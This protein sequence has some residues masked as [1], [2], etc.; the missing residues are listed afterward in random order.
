MD[1]LQW[2]GNC[3]DDRQKGRQE[4]F[5]R[6]TNRN[7]NKNTTVTRMKRILVALFLM[8]GFAGFS[9]FGNQQTQQDLV[10]WSYTTEKISETDYNLI[11]KASIEPQWHVYSQFTKPGGPMPLE[12]SFENSGTDFELVG[13]AEEGDTY[14]EYNDIFEV[15]ETF[16]KD[17]LLVT[18]R[19][20]L[21]KG[22]IS[23]VQGSL[24][25]Q[26]CKDVCIQGNQDFAF[27]LTGVKAETKKKIVSERDAELSAK[28]VLPLKNTHYI[29]NGEAEKSFWQV[30]VL[31]FLGG[32][33]ALFTPCVFPMIPLTVSFFTKQSSNKTKGKANA[34][35]YGFFIVAIYL[36]LSLPFHLI[37]GVNKEVLNNIST[38]AYLNTGF[39]V[40]F[41]VFAISFFGYFEITLPQSWSNKMDNASNVGGLL[42]IFFMAV[43][44]A[45]VSFSCTGPIL[46][47]LLAGS[48]SSDGGAMQ[49][50]VGMGGFGLALALPFAIFALFPNLLTS[51]PK[52]GGWMTTTKVFL[53]YL[54]LAFAFKFFSNAD[55]VMHWGILKWEIFVGVWILI[56][57]LLTLYMFGV[58]RFPH[59]G[60]GKLSK[61]RLAIGVISG[62]FSVYLIL[63]LVG[64]NKLELLSGFPPQRSYSLF[65]H[66]EKSEL[67]VFQDFD[68]G[69]AFAKENDKLV[70]LDFTGWAC[71]NCRKV[72]EQIWTDAEVGKLLKDH[73]VI[74]SMYVDDR[75]KLAEEEQFNYQYDNGNVKSIKTVG[76]KWSTL[77]DI[78]FK[79]ISQPFYV[80]MTPDY[81]LLNKPMQYEKTEVYLAWLKK[82]IDNS[83]K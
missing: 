11:F 34:F 28:L 24:T 21:L 31:G 76:D 83:G 23:A 80:L 51:L 18:Q 20:H 68:K 22:D 13:V 49:L 56:F 32:L 45:L 52:S 19:I 43:T 44:L 48:L 41:I 35:L 17:K 73:V 5:R 36:L 82:G 15:D 58:Y 26:V 10:S 39:F 71:V 55:L 30:F 77:Q 42:G 54:E 61:G 69:I 70:M 59:D 12:I 50:T 38:N 72:E 64:V 57:V 16:F 27:S 74:I 67:T 3:L 79:S 6:R 37:E 40:I 78:N 2:Q 7:N 53:G 66:E 65:T 62:I 25:Y 63:G 75:M 33:L 46:G 14:T 1:S 29:G 47:S 8:I 4:V 81:E 9:Q 60:K